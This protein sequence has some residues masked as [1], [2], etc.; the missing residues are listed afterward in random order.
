MKKLTLAL[1]LLI[2]TACSVKLMTPIQSDVDRVSHKFP[3]YSLAE[4]EQGKANYENKCTMCHG[5]KNPKSESEEE[6]RKIVPNMVKA[7]NKKTETIDPK[8]EESI[9]KYVITMSSAPK[10]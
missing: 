8:T 6:W 5:L 10:R 9:L 2:I 1:S 7:A 3:G 4:L